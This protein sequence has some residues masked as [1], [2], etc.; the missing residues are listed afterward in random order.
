ME[1]TKRRLLWHG[2]LLFLFGLL[3]GLVEQKFDNPRMGL[4]AHLE[5]IMN[6]TFLV[7]LGAVWAEVRLSP[8]L[9]TVAYW[10]AL[11]GTYANWAVTTLAAM[12]G[13]AA[14]SPI[15]AAGHSAQPWQ[16]SSVTFGFMS[17]GMAI[18][19]SSVL[20]LRGLRRTAVR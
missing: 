14:M 16:E 15:T 6:G 5:G 10:S 13:T 20:I 3:T 4:A 2:M 12:F 1:D 17:V 9:K 19:A 7:A 18:I 8:R 11:Y